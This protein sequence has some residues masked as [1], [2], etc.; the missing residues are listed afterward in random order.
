MF[1]HKRRW[2]SQG[3]WVFGIGSGIPRTEQEKRN[4]G[5][6]TSK[7]VVEPGTT[8]ISNRFS[9]Y[10]NLNSVGHSKNFVDPTK[11]PTQTR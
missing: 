5:D 10:F 1:G 3:T 7:E 2:V 6:W 4:L 11:A 9:P 8:I